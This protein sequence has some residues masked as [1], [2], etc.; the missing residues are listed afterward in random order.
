MDPFWIVPTQK[1]SHVRVPWY[2]CCREKEKKKPKQKGPVLVL[3]DKTQLRVPW[4][5]FRKN[6]KTKHKREKH[7]FTIQGFPIFRQVHGTP[8]RFSPPPPSAPSP[9]AASAGW[10]RR[11]PTA[12]PQRGTEAGGDPGLF[13]SHTRATCSKPG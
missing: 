2:G 3:S 11:G 4:W 8:R 1:A 5:S 9:R 7:L 10:A 6:I 12:P 13:R